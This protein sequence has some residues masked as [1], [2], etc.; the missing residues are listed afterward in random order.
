MQ[1]LLKQTH[2]PQL[3]SNNILIN[4]SN[5]SAKRLEA[6]LLANEVSIEV[7]QQLKLNNSSSSTK[8]EQNLK[9]S[10]KFQQKQQ[11]FTKSFNKC[12]KVE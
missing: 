2:W 1:C 4:L 10:T 6:Q 11:H 12:L 8:E 5:P 9:A 7:Y 3:T